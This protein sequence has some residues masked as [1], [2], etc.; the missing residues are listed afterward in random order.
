MIYYG[1]RFERRIRLILEG[2]IVTAAVIHPSFGKVKAG[3]KGT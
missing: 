3:N 2:G 1:F